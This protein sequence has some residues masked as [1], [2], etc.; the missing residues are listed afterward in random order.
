YQNMNAGKL[1]VSIDLSMPEGRQ[2]VTDLVRWADVMTESFTPGAMA[3]WGLDYASVREINPSIV[4]MSSCLMGQTG[5]LNRFAGYGN[6]AAAFC[7]FTGMVGWPDRP[8]AGPFGAYSDYVSPRFALCA[9]LA[10]LDHRRRTGEGQ[11]LDFAQA[12]AAVH[13][14]TPA[15]LDYVVNGRVASRNGNADLDM[16]PHGVYPSAGDDQWVAIACR[17][18]ADW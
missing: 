15:L 6:L 14:L 9:L 3:A 4:M 13:F 18:D 2:V 7:G 1:N 16:A 12:E 5:P 17:D 10:A 11:Y 8:P